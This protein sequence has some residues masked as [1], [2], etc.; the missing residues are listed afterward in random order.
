MDA[1]NND[2]AQM[3]EESGAPL[4]DRASV[5]EPDEDFA[6]DDASIRT[7]LLSHVDA[8]QEVHI[9]H[10]TSAK[11]M[12]DA[13]KAVH[14]NP[15]GNRAMA[16]LR[17]FLNF[18][19]GR[20]N[21]D[22]TATA[23]TDLDT[24]ICA[25]APDEAPSETWRSLKLTEAMGPSFDFANRLLTEKKVARFADAVA[26]LK[27]EEHLIAR[28]KAQNEISHVTQHH[29]L[30][31]RSGPARKFQ[32]RC[33]NC[34][35]TGHRMTECRSPPNS[36]A[37]ALNKKQYGRKAKRTEQ[38]QQ[39]AI[40]VPAN[41]PAATSDEHAAIARGSSPM[42]ICTALMATSCPTLPVF[43]L[44]KWVLESSASTHMTPHR[45][46]F[47]TYKLLS[48]PIPLWVTDG[49]SVPAVAKGT[50]KNVTIR[51]VYH[52]PALNTSL[53]SVA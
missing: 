37:Q 17:E 20:R 50:V 43:S 47:G 7:T 44:H 34:A 41:A 21:I 36:A 25:M 4:P 49:R 18:E 38:K 15:S 46:H 48:K 51:D 23:L 28:R 27:E 22:E 16:L 31:V 9:I 12:W 11:E 40:R 52:V 14:E 19:S 5:I 32:G 39:Q 42:Y 10:L 29:G 3:V 30:A 33:F 35:K 6:V 8:T 13:L 53:V 24:R 45:S 2:A 26:K 1:G